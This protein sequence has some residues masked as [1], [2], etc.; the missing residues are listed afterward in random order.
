MAVAVWDTL[1]HLPAYAILATLLERLAGQRAADAVRA[2]FVLGDREAL[3]ALFAEAGVEGARIATYPGTARFPSIRVMV[4]A[5]LR[6]WLPLMGVDLPEEQILH[7]LREAEDALRP[8]VSDDGRV[9]FPAPAHIV[10][11]TRA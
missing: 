5:E 11:A 9:T 8:Y 3:A 1:E 6:G 4:E 2:P 10:V 7:I